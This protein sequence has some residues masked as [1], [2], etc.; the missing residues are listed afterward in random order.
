MRKNMRKSLLNL[1]FGVGPG[2]LSACFTTLLFFQFFFFDSSVAD[3]LSLPTRHVIPFSALLTR[4][5]CPIL[6][7]Y[8]LLAPQPPHSYVGE[9]TLW[10]GIATLSSS[11]LSHAASASL[12]P[13]W[14]PYTVLLSPLFEYLLLT[15]ASGVPI[16]EKSAE[17]KWGETKEWKEYKSK[18]PVFF[19][20]PG[21]KI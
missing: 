21:S 8:S 5:A 12:I 6:S 20:W 4:S 10:A 11:A 13:A 17:K 19:A 16:L 15:K 14:A 1:E 3:I 7:I 2:I 9:V 18:V